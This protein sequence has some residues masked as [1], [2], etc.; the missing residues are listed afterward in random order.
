M[1]L[2]VHIHRLAKGEFS[3]FFLSLFL[4]RLSFSSWVGGT[5]LFLGQG[6]RRRRREG[7]KDRRGLGRTNY[8]NHQA[9]PDVVIMIPIHSLGLEDD[10]VISFAV[11]EWEWIQRR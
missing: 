7:V 3:D 8:P 6:S 2:P 9:I 10:L 4:S 5:I 1:D 11:G